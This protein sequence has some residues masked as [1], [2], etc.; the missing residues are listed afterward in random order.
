MG[1]D[2]PEKHR[3]HRLF[4]LI[5]NKRGDVYKKKFCG[6]AFN[7]TIRRDGK[8]IPVADWAKKNEFEVED[9]MEEKD[10]ETISRVKNVA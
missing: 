3:T 1:K 8:E 7:G 9:L 2:R 5:R 4:R 10:V 6:Y